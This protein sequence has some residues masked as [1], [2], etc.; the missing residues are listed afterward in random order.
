MTI[1]RQ[2]DLFFADGRSDK[3]YHI[4][5]RQIAASE[6]TVEFSYGRR[7]S[8]LK[9]GEKTNSRPVSFHIANKLFDAVRNEKLAKGYKEAVTAYQPPQPTAS[10]ESKLN[11]YHTTVVRVAEISSST[12]SVHMKMRSTIVGK[13][14]IPPNAGI[15][16]VGD[17]I[18]VRYLYAYPGGAL[19]QPTYIRTR[20]DID[21]EDSLE[22]LKMKPLQQSVTSSVDTAAFLAW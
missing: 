6:Y 7:G 4:Y 22:S 8:T 13:V 2:S 19:Y 9:T 20:V 16:N 15:P 1:V 10:T 14:T 11:L 12:R 5:I 17:L 18:E 3:E 21:T